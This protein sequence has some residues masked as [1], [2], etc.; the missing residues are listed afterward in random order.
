MARTDTVIKDISK[1]VEIGE[2]S[3]SVI[4]P[5][6]DSDDIFSGHQKD[7]SNSNVRTYSKS[8]TGNKYLPIKNKVIN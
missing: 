5:K 1:E 3:K 6:T 8:K 4:V 2:G 7:K